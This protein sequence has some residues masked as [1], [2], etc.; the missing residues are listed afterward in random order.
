[1]AS[2]S[3]EHVYKVYPGGVRAITDL[4][5]AI[6]DKEFV[7][8]VGPSGCG[9]STT[10]RMI[11]GL[12]EISAGNLY[13]DG[14]RVN[15]L[16]PSKRD[17]TMVF[18]NYALYPHKTVY[19]N[20]AFGLRMQKLPPDEIDRRIKAA[21]KILGLEPYLTRKPRALSGGQRQRVA[22]GRSIVRE[23]KV[24][25]LDEPLSNLDAKLRVQ[26]RAEISKLH[27]RLG[28]TFVYVTHDQTEAMTM[29]TEI[30]VMKDGLIQQVDTPAN[31]YDHPAN[32]FVATFLGTPQMN[33]FDG[34]LEE[35][36]GEW[37]CYVREGDYEL[38]IPL[39]KTM[40]SLL[41]EEAKD[42]LKV[43][44]GIRP[45]DVLID[46][47]NP[48]FEIVV[49]MIE[50]LGAELILYCYLKGSRIRLLLRADG[51]LGVKEGEVLPVR[52]DERRFHLF[53]GEGEGRR[54][55]GLMSKNYLEATLDGETGKVMCLGASFQLSPEEMERLV[56]GMRGKKDG[57]CALMVGSRSFHLL[58]AGEDDLHFKAKVVSLEE[59]KE[60][61]LLFFSLPGRKSYVGAKFPKVEKAPGEEIDLYVSRKEAVLVD[62]GHGH[63]L[64][65]LHPY[66]RNLVDAEVVL[67]GGR[68]HLRFASFDLLC[69]EEWEVGSYELEIPYDAF[70]KASRGKKARKKKKK[71]SLLLR[72]GWDRLMV[73]R[74]EKKRALA[75][76]DPAEIEA[77]K[78]RRLE[79]KEARKAK[80][81][82][83]KARKKAEEK[84]RKEALRGRTFRIHPVNEDHLGDCTILY[85]N[86]KGF[87]DYLTIK[88]EA[89][90]SCFGE[91][92]PAYALDYG[93]LVL[94]KK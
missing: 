71:L 15:D 92:R 28:T 43:R 66:T 42:G 62:E 4:N 9:K 24:F 72:E 86:V 80:E 74:A 12:E 29:G 85:A 51:R 13:I 39:G 94:R 82:E 54:L 90:D 73:L 61:T 10:L 63:R 41:S 11:A 75:G 21:A 30:V 27:R 55:A 20:M 88:G 5:L 25:L 1:M 38:R 37:S 59:G 46:K 19:E 31:L 84:A 34:T 35:K 18:Q 83:E 58:P 33:L 36:G 45:E 2:V 22:L 32:V 14:E 68:K 77:E 79:E 17:I 65:A 48:Q 52:L 60:E 76:K 8:F 67:K 57:K 50:K 47:E 93:K 44:L 78:K 81:K 49:D 70:L 26:M 6:K 56:P 89:E 91:K 7:V 87:K 64:I 23:P 53:E 40:G 3:F 69:P 16:P